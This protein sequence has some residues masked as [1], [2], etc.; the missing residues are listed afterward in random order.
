MANDI[1]NQVESLFS[2]REQW[3][4]FLELVSEKGNIQ[5]T[6]W[7]TLQPLMTKCFKGD[8]L[9]NGWGFVSWGIWDYKWYLADFGEKSLC[10]WAREWYGN[11]SLTLWADRSQYDTVEISNLLDDPAYSPIIS[12]F[13][14]P[15][16]NFGPESDVKI[17]DQGDYIFDGLK[18]APR[19]DHLS[20][21]AHYKPE[22]FVSQMLE[23]I[24]R[25]RK[26]STITDLLKKI[27]SVTVRKP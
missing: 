19:M 9:V 7:Q 18:L 14:S 1:V 6:W 27:N 15:N 16:C 5:S 21:Y 4:S 24:D 8:N 3:T 11:Y 12:V 25:F 10:L 2:D 20:W 26:D 23:R 22:K 17:L 13:E